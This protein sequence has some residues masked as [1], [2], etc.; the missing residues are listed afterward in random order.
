[1]ENV[2]YQPFSQA[3]SDT[4]IRKLNNNKAPGPDKIHPEFGTKARNTLLSFCNHVWT[5]SVPANWKKTII[6][7]VLKPGKP[8]DDFKNYRSIAVTSYLSEVRNRRYQKN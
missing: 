6:I 7:S 4:A 3:E 1:M 2:F 5:T 8:A